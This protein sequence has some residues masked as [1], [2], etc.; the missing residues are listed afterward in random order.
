[1]DLH[2]LC[3]LVVSFRNMQLFLLV[4]PL[5]AGFPL[6]Y[7]KRKPFHWD[8]FQ[9]SNL[10]L[11]Y[12]ASFWISTYIFESDCIKYSCSEGRRLVRNP[13]C[14]LLFPCSHNYLP[15]H[16]SSCHLKLLQANHY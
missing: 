14:S 11:A 5:R 8:N 1:M 16:Q 12:M 6:L 10:N 4:H 15:S 2:P 13:D 9:G 7:R 3:S